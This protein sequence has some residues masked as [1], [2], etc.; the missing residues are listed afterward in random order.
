MT[1]YVIQR[2]SD[3]WTWLGYANQWIEDPAYGMS[4]ESV[5]VAELAGAKE[6]PVSVEAWTVVALPGTREPEDAA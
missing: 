6:I 5:T 3:G 4:F 2:R 1:R